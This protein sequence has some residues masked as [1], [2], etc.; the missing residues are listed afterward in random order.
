VTAVVLLGEPLV[1]GQTVGAGLILA[2]LL[3]L[4]RDGPSDPFPPS[5]H[6]I[7]AAN[8]VTTTR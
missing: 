3:L 8:T 1:G 4:T 2:C 6:D 7:P 5:S